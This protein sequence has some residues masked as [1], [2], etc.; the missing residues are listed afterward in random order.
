MKKTIFAF[1]GM[2]TFITD[3]Q[4]VD[5]VVPHTFSSGT[6]I[7]SADVNDNFTTIYRE[8]NALRN[9]I[10]SKSCATIHAQSPSLPSGVYSIYPT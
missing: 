9:R 8:L 2:L 1:A 10:N 5:L 3:A 4:A 7:R 6:P